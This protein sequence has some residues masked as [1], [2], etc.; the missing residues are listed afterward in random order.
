MGREIAREREKEIEKV[1]KREGEG[2][3]K[4]RERGEEKGR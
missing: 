1:I 4:R 3:G 2:V